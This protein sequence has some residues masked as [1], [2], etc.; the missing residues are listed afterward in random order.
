MQISIANQSTSKYYVSKAQNPNK[1]QPSFKALKEIA[2]KW[3][4]ES[5]IAQTQFAQDAIL[6]SLKN[7]DLKNFFNNVD[8]KILFLHTQNSTNQNTKHSLDL[9][10]NVEDSPILKLRT[11]NNLK[12]IGIKFRESA[13]EFPKINKWWNI[14]EFKTSGTDFNSVLSEFLKK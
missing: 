2:F 3:S 1:G 13:I 10:I 6:K 7:S 12:K 9:V 14:T 8:G 4:P 5:S 11:I